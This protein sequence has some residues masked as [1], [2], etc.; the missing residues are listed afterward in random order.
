LPIKDLI[1][2]LKVSRKTI[3][4]HRKYIIA[5]VIIISEDLPLLKQYISPESEV[6]KI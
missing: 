6:E 5:L 2:I 3:E 1:S 4:K